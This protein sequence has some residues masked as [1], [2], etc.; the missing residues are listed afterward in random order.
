MNNYED[1]EGY[2]IQD[3]NDCGMI[4]KCDGVPCLVFCDMSSN[5]DPEDFDSFKRWLFDKFVKDVKEVIDKD[6]DN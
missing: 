5:K 2:H 4:I 3:M 6:A 1:K